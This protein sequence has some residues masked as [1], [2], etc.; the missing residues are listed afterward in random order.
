MPSTY[1]PVSVPAFPQFDDQDSLNDRL[2]TLFNTFDNDGSG[3]APAQHW[4]GSGEVLVD[5]PPAKIKRFIPS[6]TLSHHNAT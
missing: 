6:L 1:V 5:T 2:E 4:H 3:T